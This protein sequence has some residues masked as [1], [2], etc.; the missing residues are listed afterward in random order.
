[1]KFLFC[2]LYLICILIGFLFYN[3]VYN[4]L[5][6]KYSY[7]NNAMFNADFKCLNIFQLNIGV[8]LCFVKKR[9]KFKQKY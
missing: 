4:I 7:I 3:Y 6:M 8:A 9:T 2:L 5:L 1:M